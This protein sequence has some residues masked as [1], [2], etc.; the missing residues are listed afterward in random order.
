[1]WCKFD[2]DSRTLPAQSTISSRR[3]WARQN[4]PRGLRGITDLHNQISGPFCV[5]ALRPG[6]RTD[7]I[8]E[9]IL[10]KVQIILEC[11]VVAEEGA[12]ANRGHVFWSKY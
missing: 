10:Q 4:P 1:M 6:D 12:S 3:N 2:A 7:Y 8:I 9:W 11:L 5:A